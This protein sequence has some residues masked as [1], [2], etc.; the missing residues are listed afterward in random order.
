MSKCSQLNYKFQPLLRV[1]GGSNLK[2]QLDITLTMS[3]LKLWIITSQ[4]IFA[5]SER[6]YQVLKN[7][8][9]YS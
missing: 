3:F 2:H 9:T 7:D 6:S 4:S 8:V 1:Q 5:Y